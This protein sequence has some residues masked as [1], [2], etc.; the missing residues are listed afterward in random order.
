VSVVLGYALVLWLWPS[1]EWPVEQRVAQECRCKTK[2]VKQEPGGRP[3]ASALCL[4]RF[5]GLYL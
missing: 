3:C 5:S 1:A 2:A 4:L